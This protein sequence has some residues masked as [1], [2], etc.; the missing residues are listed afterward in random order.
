M[1]NS[2]II[3]LQRNFNS[4]EKQVEIKQKSM[5]KQGG[6][7]FCIVENQALILKRPSVACI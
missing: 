7:C 5:Q 4:S 6:G 1:H 3:D 2:R